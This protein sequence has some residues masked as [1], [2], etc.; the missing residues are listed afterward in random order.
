MF[1]KVFFSF[2]FILLISPFILV[3]IGNV[4]PPEIKERPFTE[5]EIKQTSTF[6]PKEKWG[7]HQL[8]LVG[9]SFQRGQQ[10]GYWT[11]DFLLE[12]EQALIEKLN[13]VMPNKFFQYGLF[14]F[15]M[16]W[17]QGLDS[18]FEKPWL[19]EMYGVSLHGSKQNRFFA[20]PYT[21]Q[22]AY[23]GIHDMGQMMID[24]GLVMG[25]CTQIARP[26]EKG[27]LIG[28]NFDFEGGRVFDED[29]ILK[30]VF[31]EQGHAF[32]SV[33]FSGMVGVI[34]GV[35][36]Q[37]VYVAINAAGSEDFT[38][39]GTP[40]SLL[41]LKALQFSKTAAEAIQILEK[42][43]PLITDIF[44]IADRGPRLFIVEKTPERTRVIEK[45]TDTVVTNHLQHPDFSSDKTNQK[46]ISN[47]T[48]LRRFQ[49]AKE[50]LPSAQSELDLLKIL[51]DKFTF[52]D[53]IVFGHRNSIDALIASHS[54]VYN[55]AA[56]R[57][58]IAKGPSLS[59]EFVG[60]DLQAS[61]KQRQPIMLPSLPA[62]SDFEGKDFYRLKKSLKELK[63][64]RGQ[65]KRG[66]CQKAEQNF[67]LLKTPK[68]M[69]NHYFYHWTK[70]QIALCFGQSLA[71]KDALTKALEREPAYFWERNEIEANLK[72]L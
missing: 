55:S 17:F 24:H 14:L 7:V 65:A 72:S 26:I 52:N 4:S 44:V 20:S 38:R 39:L 53:N 8:F 35:N 29:K 23:H 33:I 57:L 13:E 36:E 12:Q 31:P 22:I 69:E 16:G 25:A 58:Y 11:H 51:R 56:Q 63:D 70:G 54:L 48:T 71:A 30:W 3:Q 27:W 59:Q 5:E 43:H 21:R 28:R 47:N 60:V 6:F 1:K 46:R 9:N 10:Y 18:Y 15:S 62:D 37:G 42:A 50:L 68:F 41:A 40:T 61:F 45:K 32:V 66:H 19:N 49:K 34:S 67:V 2:L 64:L